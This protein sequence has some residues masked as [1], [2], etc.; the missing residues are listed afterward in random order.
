MLNLARKLA[1]F[2][3]SAALASAVAAEPYPSE[4]IRIVVT[5]TP[6]GLPDLISRWL[7]E[8]L[9]PALGQPIVVE[10]RPGAGGNIAMQAAARSAPDGYTLVVAGQGPFALNPHI[11]INPGYDPI[12][13]FAPITQIERGALILAA[14]PALPVRSV[15][16]LIELAKAKPGELNYG[17]PGTGTPLTWRA[18]YSTGQRRSR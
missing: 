13:D 8:Q 18:S 12:A 9:S 10:N 16:E 11:Y 15:R 6:G 3:L 17:S 2:A 1:V 4:P 14:Y 7:A 5:G